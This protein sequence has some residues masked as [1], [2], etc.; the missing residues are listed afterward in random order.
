MAPSPGTSQALSPSPVKLMRQENIAG[1]F[2]NSPEIKMKL[3]TV[4]LHSIPRMTETG[5]RPYL[6][7]T[8]SKN[9]LVYTSMV[10]GVRNA[11]FFDGVI[12]FHPNVE[13]ESEFEIRVYHLPN[14]RPGVRCFDTK[15]RTSSSA[16]LR[17]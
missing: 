4:V 13:V 11:T 7:I 1:N 12:S 17:I 9:N 8:D 5:C 16:C 2:A 14:G 6:M 10:N 3:R 15:I